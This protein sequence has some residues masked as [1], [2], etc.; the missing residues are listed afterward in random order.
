MLLG[1][2]SQLVVVLHPE[3]LL[4]HGERGIGRGVRAFTLRKVQLRS[5][6]LKHVLLLLRQGQRLGL[7]D[8]G[9]GRGLVRHLH[10]QLLRGQFLRSL[11]F[12]G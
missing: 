9:K 5:K 6:L 3:G 2:V 7:R 11:P 4:L 12:L 10:P 8:P 1:L